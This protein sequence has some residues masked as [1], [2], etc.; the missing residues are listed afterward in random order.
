MKVKDMNERQ[1][2]AFYNIK[3]A[4]N[5]LVGGLENT[6][7]DYPEDSKEFKSAKALL[8]D[9]DALVKEL[10][11]RATSSVYREGFVCFGKIAEMYIRDIN[12][13][14]KEWLMERCERRISK[15]GY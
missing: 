12:F 15:M 4:A 6:M 14:G 5:D 1:K 9:H 3:Y 2:K 7:L 8:A 11:Y 13:C 10:Y